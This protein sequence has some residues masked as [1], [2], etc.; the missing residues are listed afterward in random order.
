LKE[1]RSVKKVTSNPVAVGATVN[2]VVSAA[3]AVCAAFG[4]WTPTPDQVAAV[5]GLTT[6]LEAVVAVFVSKRVE[7]IVPEVKA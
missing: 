1:T 5:L 6:A 7:T 4:V 3:L 2:G